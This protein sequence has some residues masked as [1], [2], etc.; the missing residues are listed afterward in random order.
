MTLRVR[1]WSVP[2]TNCLRSS[3]IYHEWNICCTCPLT[4][5][6]YAGVRF[7]I[8]TPNTI[9]NL[10]ESLFK[11]GVSIISEQPSYTKHRVFRFFY[12]LCN[13]SSRLT[14]K[15]VLFETPSFSKN[16]NR[17]YKY[18]VWGKKGRDWVMKKFTFWRITLTPKTSTL[19]MSSSRCLNFWQSTFSWFMQEWF[20]SR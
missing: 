1:C 20:F 13:N 17:R 10:F 4:W 8:K 16:L 11:V 18:L 12:A 14:S 5:I 7:Y 15:L 9:R 3:E 19:K 6:P 2:G